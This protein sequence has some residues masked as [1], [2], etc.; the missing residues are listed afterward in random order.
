[1]YKCWTYT[2]LYEAFTF[3]TENIYVQFDGMVYQLIVGIPIDTN[4]DPYFADEFNIV[5]Y[6]RFFFCKTFR[7]QIGLT[8]LTSQF[9]KLLC[10]AKDH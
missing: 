7:N 2:E 4:S 3:L 9:L 6:K 1:M 10:L 8:S 5:E